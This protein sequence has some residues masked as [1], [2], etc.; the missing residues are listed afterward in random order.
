MIDPLALPMDAWVGQ[1]VRLIE[2]VVTNGGKKFAKGLVCKVGSHYRGRLR[3]ESLEG[4]CLVTGVSR[5]RVEM[6]DPPTEMPRKTAKWRW[7]GWSG[8]YPVNPTAKALARKNGV[9][10]FGSWVV[11]MTEL[12]AACE[13]HGVACAVNR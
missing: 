11:E 13:A 4:T 3:L 6:V 7:N 8:Y 1:V 10:R 9:G 2:N 12:A 5:C